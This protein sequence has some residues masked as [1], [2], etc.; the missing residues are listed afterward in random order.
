MTSAENLIAMFKAAKCP[1]SSDQESCMIGAMAFYDAARA[2]ETEK[3]DELLFAMLNLLQDNL[4]A[5][6]NEE[7]SV[8]EEHQDLI[9]STTEFLEQFY[10]P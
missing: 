4:A 1:L 7:D 6:E 3:R 2:R 5:W 9:D 8:R 10:A